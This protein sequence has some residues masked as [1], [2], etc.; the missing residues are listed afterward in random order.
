[1]LSN[2][3]DKWD[4]KKD[5]NPNIRNAMDREEDRKVWKTYRMEKA[6][7]NLG[8]V[9]MVRPVP[10]PT[11]PNELDNPVEEPE[12]LEEFMQAMETSF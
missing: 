2:I 4:Y 9:H 3:L 6:V 1:M 7:Y 12:D 8:R 11:P 5:S 10:N